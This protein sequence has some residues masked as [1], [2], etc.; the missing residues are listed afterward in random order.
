MAHDQ[1]ENFIPTLLKNGDGVKNTLI[2]Q[3]E[4][5]RDELAVEAKLF[6]ILKKAKCGVQTR[7]GSTIYHYEDLKEAPEDTAHIFG[8][9]ARKSEGSH[10]RK[11]VRLPANNEM[12][13]PM[14]LSKD[15]LLYLPKPSEFGFKQSDFI[16]RDSE[17]ACLNFI[18]GETAGLERLNEYL[19]KY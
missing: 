17:R 16:K 1:P 13:L 14:D 7:W 8:N 6:K 5:C 4:V 12:P 2:Y 18:G 9:F 19:W 3:E 11:C 15:H 10:I